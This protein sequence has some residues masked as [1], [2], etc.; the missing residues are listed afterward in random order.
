ML[1]KDLDIDIP[2]C[3]TNATCSKGSSNMLVKR[4]QLILVSIHF[5]SKQPLSKRR[6]LVI[7]ESLLVRTNFFSW[8]QKGASF[9]GKT[10][11][12]GKVMRCYFNVFPHMKSRSS[13]ILKIVFEFMFTTMTQRTRCKGPSNR[14][15]L[16]I[17]TN[18]LGID[19]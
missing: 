18:V 4:M 1:S 10:K 9:I 2:Y 17:Y 7:Q 12:V 13:C 19:I 8:V 5:W 14:F 3:T 16:Y 15:F 6:I 11:I